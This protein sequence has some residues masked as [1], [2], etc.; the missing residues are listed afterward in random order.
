MIAYV[1]TQGSRIIK[2]GRHLVVKADDGGT[3]TLFVYR[4]QQLVVCGNVQLTSQAMRLLMQE[5]VDTVFLRSD[6]RYVGRLAGAESKNVFLRRNQFKL[7]D[8]DTFNLR[9]AS[10]IVEGKLIN[11]M[12]VLQRLR[13]SRGLAQV[14]KPID[15]IRQC[16][17]R[18][19]E[20][21]EVDQVRGLEGAGSA[22]FFQGYRCAFAPELGFNNRVRRPPTDPVNSVLSLL[23]T[24]LINRGYAAVRLVG[25]DPYPAFLHSP[26]YGRH[27]LPLD[28]IE[29][30]RTILAETLTLALFSLR[31]L[32]SDDFFTE[33]SILSCVNEKQ[34]DDIE[35]ACHDPLGAV[36]GEDAAAVEECESELFD[37]PDLRLAENSAEVGARSGKN[38]VRLRP[39]A[40]KKVINAFEKK[41]LTQFFHAGAQK[42]M[43]YADAL[44]YQARLLRQ[45]IEGESERYY[46]LLL[47]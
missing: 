31:V 33:Q 13:R 47:K 32:D 4:L 3:R 10:S 21:A 37:V 14:A 38:A 16:L 41:L 8:D 45:V 26:E 20:V 12:R 2:Q 44:V 35:R 30:F 22:A 11:Q 18:L 36:S 24:F 17:N 46:P 28:L 43:T 7:L 1:T 40:F 6:G 5:N 27:S 42:R 29:E 39:A 23:Y 15:K 19:G 34:D 9:V 25:L